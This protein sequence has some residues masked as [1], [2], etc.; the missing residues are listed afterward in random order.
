MM[1]MKCIVGL[2]NPG[3]KYQN[4]RHN[5]GFWCV[6][7][8]ARAQGNVEAWKLDAKHHAEVLTLHVEG[9]RVLFVKPQT[10]MNLSG[11]SVAPLLAYYKVAPSD[12]LV[13]HDDA[14]LALHASKWSYDSRSGG[15]NG[16]KSIIEHL[17]TQAFYRLRLGVG[18]SEVLDLADYVLQPMSESER[19]AWQESLPSLLTQIEAWIRGEYPT[20]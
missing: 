18:R 15:Q 17:G 3:K 12:L 6:E 10:F 8:L 14:D 2:G 16:V 4:T 5:I 19:S 13:I 20:K 11:E 1:R 9:E 7:E